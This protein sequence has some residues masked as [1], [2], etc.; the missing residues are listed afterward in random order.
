M[1]F[2][3]YE[4]DEKAQKDVKV[5]MVTMFQSTVTIRHDSLEQLFIWLYQKTKAKCYR[6]AV[7][8]IFNVDDLTVQDRERAKLLKKLFTCCVD[9]LIKPKIDVFSL[10]E[11]IASLCEAG[12]IG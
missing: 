2:V 4:D 3:L 7:I 10:F 11:D 1:T 9:G 5:Y 12:I 8:L 6:D